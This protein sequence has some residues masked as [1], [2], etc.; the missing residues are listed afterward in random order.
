MG[1]TASVDIRT[2]SS[3]TMSDV[4]KFAPQ[5]GFKLS[6]DLLNKAYR[7]IDVTETEFG[8][9]KSFMVT[10]ED[11]EG[12]VINVSA[13]AL[14]KAR[15][16]G[17]DGING[18]T[19][20]EN[21]QNIFVRSQAEEIWNSSAYFHA[22][23]MK[24]DEEFVLPEQIKFRYAVLAEDQESN[25]PMLNPFLYKGYRKV[26]ADYAKRDEFP[27]MEDF[28]EELLKSATDGR[29]AGLPGGLMEPTPNNW[30]KENEVSNFRHTLVIEDFE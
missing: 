12:H 15:V 3:D 1:N 30:V 13:A 27:T 25:K 18:D 21:T 16:L 11:E 17:K 10:L 28:K 5:D 24:K 9:N 29:I 14:K 19:P 7:V 8:T 6:D 4:M 2:I 26:V 22:K 23:G 20:F